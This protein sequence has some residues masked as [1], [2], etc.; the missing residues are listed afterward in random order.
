MSYLD[1]V[2]YQC[3][4]SRVV[5]MRVVKKAG[6]VGMSGIVAGTEIMNFRLNG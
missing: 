3:P 5:C 1:S 4:V 2:V 6:R